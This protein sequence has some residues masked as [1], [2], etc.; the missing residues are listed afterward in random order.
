MVCHLLAPRA[1]LPKRYVSGTVL[2]AS[3]D[4]RRTMGRLISASVRPPARSEK[5]MCRYKTK[6]R[7]PNIPNMMEGMPARLSAPNLTSFV[8]R[9]SPAY[10]AM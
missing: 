9:F 10:S 2:I 4:T 7:Y 6:N 3:S 1:R 5:P 8:R